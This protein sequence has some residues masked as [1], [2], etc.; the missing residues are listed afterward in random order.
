MQTTRKRKAKTGDIG[1]FA[2]KR[3]IPHG[4]GSY[5]RDFCRGISGLISRSDYEA[6]LGSASYEEFLTHLLS[7][8]QVRRHAV[9]SR[10][11][12]QKIKF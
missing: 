7:P 12:L 6:E 9:P 11:K 1:R 2:A 10:L 5:F 4:S 3:E 8:S